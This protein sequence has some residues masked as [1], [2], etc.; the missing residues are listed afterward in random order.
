[1]NTKE[2]LLSK[3]WIL[4]KDDRDMYY[5]IKDDAKNLKRIFQDNFGYSLISHQ[6]FIKIDKAI[7][8]ISIFFFFKFIDKISPNTAGKNQVNSTQYK[9]LAK[10]TTHGDNKNVI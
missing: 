3:R 9:F 10:A 2:M 5:R 4:K 6:N 8:G 7:H 1:M